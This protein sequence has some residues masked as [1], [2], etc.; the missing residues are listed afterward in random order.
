MSG[1]VRIPLASLLLEVGWQSSAL[2]DLQLYAPSLPS[3]SHAVSLCVFTLSYPEATSH[4]GQK[5][6]LPQYD[7]ILTTHIC[8]KLISKEDHLLSSWG[9]GLPR[10]TLRNTNHGSKIRQMYKWEVSS[11]SFPSPSLSALL[12]Q[13]LCAFASKGLH[14]QSTRSVYSQVWR[15]WTGW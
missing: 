14:L 5:A 13:L 12:L 10:I 1:F 2:L 7:L 4:I 8:S 9:L 11:P 6:Y 3:S 15:K